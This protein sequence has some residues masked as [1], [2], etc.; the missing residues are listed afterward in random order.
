[1]SRREIKFRAWDRLTKT[2]AH[3]TARFEI[4]DA[5]DGH[6]SFDGNPEI[7]PVGNG[8]VERYEIMQFTGLHDKNG[9]EIWE[10]DV[11]EITLPG[12]GSE[13]GVM[14]FDEERGRFG[15]KG[16]DGIIFGLVTGDK[17][18]KSIGNIYENPELLK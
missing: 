8:G 13:R 3:F 11:V 15:F 10:G 14:V 17:A 2:M 12:G 7:G 5:G 18:N 4:H 9:K 1:M 6:L 16:S